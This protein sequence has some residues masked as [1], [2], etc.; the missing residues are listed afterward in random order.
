VTLQVAVPV[1]SVIAVQ[2]WVPFSVKVTGSLGTG[3]SPL[4]VVS[5]AV[6]GV[7]TE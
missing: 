3:V 6:T 7:E 1:A 2:V 4:V 5:T